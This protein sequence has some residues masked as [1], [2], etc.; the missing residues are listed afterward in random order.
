MHEILILSGKGGTGKTSLAAA[1]AHQCPRSVFCDLDVDAPDLHLLLRP[2]E[3][4]PV[5]FVSGAEAVIDPDRCE[6]CGTCE[7]LCRFRAIRSGVPAP[8]V[9]PV[10]C[11]GC[12]VCVH[13]CPAGAIDF[14]PKTCGRWFV[15]PTRFG[16]LVHAQLF[17]GE[18]NSGKL[19]TLLR[20][21]ARK[22]AESLGAELVLSDGP[23][24]IGCPVISS[25]SGTSLAVMVT[26]PTPSGLH[27]LERVVGLC[28]HF[29]IPS[30]VVVNKSDLNRQG[31]ER[32]RAFCRKRGLT[33][34]AEIPYDPV[35]VEAMVEGLTVTEHSRGK[36]ARAV[37]SAWKK[38]MEAAQVRE[39]A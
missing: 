25:L 5:P 32:I 14:V 13:F 30:T 8:S 26:E 3:T 33:V 36:T 37:A 20:Q 22:L 10:R 18:E 29:R 21:E 35:F 4:E 27:D 17:P 6:A 1:F 34:A 15:S 31:T 9:D 2:E 19:V 23:P 39:A 28:A 16:P 7:T 12:K 38:V 11:E 24:G